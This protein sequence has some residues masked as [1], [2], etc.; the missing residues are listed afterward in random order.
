[1]PAIRVNWPKIV[2][3]VAEEDIVTIIPRRILHVLLASYHHY[4]WRATF[5][6]G[7]YDYADWDYLQRE[8]AR[9]E[10]LLGTPLALS[11]LITALNTIASYVDTVETLLQQIKAA[12]GLTTGCCNVYERYDFTGGAQ[13]TDE[14]TDGAGDVPQNIIDAGFASG[15]SDWTG[16]AEYKCMVAHLIIQG[17]AIKMG[18]LSELMDIGGSSGM[19]IA[20]ILTIVAGILVGGAVGAAAL[21]VG[22]L[23]GSFVTVAN[24]Y[25]IILEF[26]AE[27]MENLGDEILALEEQ[28]ACAIYTSTGT[29]NAILQFNNAVDEG[30]TGLAASLIKSSLTEDTIRAY[31]G[32]RYDNQDIAAKLAELGQDPADYDCSACVAPLGDDEL[33]AYWTFNEGTVDGW[34][35]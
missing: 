19:A 4:D 12:Q 9:A 11:D 10:E 28:L 18:Q 3:S 23:V 26:G 22:T 1:M 20:S 21:F 30:F 8:L 16:Y 29:A 14:V 35:L 5:N 27:N 2:A 34:A 31:L 33:D 24:L 13:Y 7:D 32:G 15:T 25:D 6:A 17:L